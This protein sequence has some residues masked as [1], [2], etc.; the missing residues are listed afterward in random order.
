M[1]RVGV[2]LHQRHDACTP[3]ESERKETPR[4]AET[5]ALTLVCWL[6]CAFD[7]IYEKE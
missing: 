4:T 7:D 3:E 2:I 6:I 5:A 1:D